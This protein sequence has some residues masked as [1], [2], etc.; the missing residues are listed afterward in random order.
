FSTIVL[1]GCGEFLDEKPRK[2]LVI[3]ETLEHLNGLMLKEAESLQ[4]PMWG[5]VSSDDYYFSPEDL[6]WEEEDYRN[7]YHWSDNDVFGTGSVNDWLFHYRFIYY[8]NTVLE[9]LAEITPT[10]AERTDW[11]RL[12][13]EAL[14]Y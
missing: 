8:T 10:V 2:G 4:D 13:G 12:M 11:E 1:L 14:F 3:P 5:E 6:D 7:A 9:K